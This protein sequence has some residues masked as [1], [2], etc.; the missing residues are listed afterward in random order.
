[1]SIV[2]PTNPTPQDVLDAV[3]NIMYDNRAAE[4]N[5]EIARWYK[6]TL[7]KAQPVYP[8]IAVGDLAYMSETFTCGPRGKD[9]RAITMG[10]IIHVSSH[11]SDNNRAKL[12]EYSEVVYNLMR[13][14][15]YNPDGLFAGKLAL[16]LT[17]KSGDIAPID[18]AGYIW[19][20]RIELEGVQYFTRTV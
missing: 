7:E 13:P 14:N 19:G 4:F 15:A 5:S 2:D 20:T 17:V 1:M 3:Y 8:L 16:P 9:R 6:D 18:V 10:I 11:L 12:R